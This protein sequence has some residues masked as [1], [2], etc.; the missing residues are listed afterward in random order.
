MGGVK[1]VII[2]N[3]VILALLFGCSYNKVDD[4]DQQLGFYMQASKD[5][6]AQSINKIEVEIVNNT[7][8]AI[9]TNLGYRIEYFDGCSWNEIPLELQVVP[10]LI[11]I[12]QHGSHSFE[13]YFHH[14]QYYYQTGNY[15][16]IKTI[17]QY[18]LEYPL[19]AQFSLISSS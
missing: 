10:I 1:R 7:S 6:Y 14:D 13:I 11:E 15:R 16:V 19:S 18:N 5:Q 4:I 8:N 17:V 2:F 3:L 12:E 9:S